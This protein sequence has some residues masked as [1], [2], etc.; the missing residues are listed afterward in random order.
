MLQFHILHNISVAIS[1]RRWVI[2]ANENSG[3]YS[4]LRAIPLSPSR[5]NRLN[6]FTR[7][8]EPVWLA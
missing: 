3:I 6:T 2:Q 4:R 1:R 7:G 8:Q 5:P